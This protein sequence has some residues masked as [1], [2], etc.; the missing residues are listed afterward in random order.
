MQHLLEEGVKAETPGK[1]QN[2][3]PSVTLATLQSAR[4]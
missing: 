4:G 2:K 1:C 3:K